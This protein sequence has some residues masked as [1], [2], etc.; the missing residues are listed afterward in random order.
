MQ[1][2]NTMFFWGFVYSFFCC[3]SA[4]SGANFVLRVRKK[5]RGAQFQASFP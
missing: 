5:L 1:Y 2:V 4:V 3:K